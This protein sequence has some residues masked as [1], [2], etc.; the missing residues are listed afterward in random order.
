[1]ILVVVTTFIFRSDIG[2]LASSFLHAAISSNPTNRN[3]VYSLTFLILN[4]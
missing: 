4:T 2:T 3:I 1:M